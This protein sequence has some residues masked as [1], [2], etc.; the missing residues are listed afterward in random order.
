MLMKNNYPLQ[1]IALL[2]SFTIVLLCSHS[3]NAYGFIVT[4]TKPDGSGAE[5]YWSN[6]S[7]GFYI[8]TTGFPSGTLEAMQA[9]M[10]TWTNVSTSNF[11]FT[12]R[13][14]IATTAYGINDGI[15]LICSGSFDAG[16][17]S[18]L[19]LNTFYYNTQTG[20]LLDSDIKFNSAFTWATDGS[21]GAYDIQS[22]G[23]H[24]LGHALS[25]DDL[26]NAGQESQTM[27]YRFSKGQIKRSLTQDDKDGIT[28]LYSGGHGTSTTTT[29]SS[30]TTTII[31]SIACPAETVLGPEHP[32]IVSLRAFRDGPLARSAVGRRITQI[33]YNNAE[34]IDAA[35]EKS[36]ALRAAARKLLE[37]IAALAR[38]RE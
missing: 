1:S 3:I 14:T 21:A 18:T 15:N 36:P 30:S 11:I 5:I 26:Y 24:E 31:I 20:F 16:Y 37:A 22:I 29:A 2:C 34:S 25:L 23:L 35:L 32:D 33:Y 10:K 8:N 12:Y 4:N 7:A 17:E 38:N 6:P 19:A 13:G 27:Y 9:A 28:Y